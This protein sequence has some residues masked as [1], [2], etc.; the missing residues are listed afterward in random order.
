M[1]D[2]DQIER[3]GNSVQALVD[4]LTD[5]LV[6][7]IA[8]R[9]TEAG[10]L[11]S[12]AAYEV[13]RLQTLGKSQ[14][15]IKK[16]I[17]KHL[18]ITSREVEQLLTQSADTGYRFD[19]RYLPSEAA[20]PIAENTAVQSILST[21]IAEANETLQNLYGTTAMGF[22]TSQELRRT[23]PLTM[24][25]IRPV[26]MCF[27]VFQQARRILIRPSEMLLQSWQSV[28]LWRWNIILGVKLI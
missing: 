19:L 28:A 22:I 26:M 13:W 7:E 21:A 9:I 4:P 23:T 10:Q 5:W 3:L 24:R 12:T 1:L 6:S 16:M 14:Q 11:T 17:Q 8:K 25:F 20:L 27:C 18:N 15:Q 2:P